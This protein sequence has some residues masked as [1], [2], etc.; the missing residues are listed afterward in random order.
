M[1]RKMDE[2]QQKL[3]EEVLE[4]SSGGGA[5]S[6]R[7]SAQSEFLSLQL[8]PEFLK[9]EDAET[10]QETVL[11]AIQEA[12]AKAKARSEEVMGEITAGL[13][14]PGMPGLM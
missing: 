5:V 9:E 1:Q 12:A 3:A 14:M 7:I 13:Q 11:A 2:A 6:I 8:D 10:V 4:V